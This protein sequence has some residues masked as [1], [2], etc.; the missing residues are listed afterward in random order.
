M[1]IEIDNWSGVEIDNW[2]SSKGNV[3]VTIRQLR[4][5]KDGKYFPQKTK[6]GGF[7]SLALRVE[8]WLKIAPQ[9]IDYLKIVNLDETDIK[10]LMERGN[11]NCSKCGNKI[12]TPLC[13]SCAKDEF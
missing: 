9:I 3:Y 6:S 5:G 2:T 11:V 13:I 12:E 10:S 1:I 4:K 7:S 8:H